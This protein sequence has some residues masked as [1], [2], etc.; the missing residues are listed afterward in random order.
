[1]RSVIIWWNHWLPSWLYFFS[2]ERNNGPQWGAD[3]TCVGEN[4]R[5]L[6]GIAPPESQQNKR[7]GQARLGFR[8]CPVLEC[9]QRRVSR[10]MWDSHQS[11][12]REISAHT[13]WA[14]T[15]PGLAS[16]TS[17]AKELSDVGSILCIIECFGNIPVLIYQ[18]ANSTQH[19]WQ[20]KHPQR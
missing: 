2:S 3:F 8:L 11:E 7:R 4:K 14:Y 6:Y 19:L 10:P 18:T 16:A 5:F 20:P 15:V 1:M 13:Y 17:K 12:R 9:Q